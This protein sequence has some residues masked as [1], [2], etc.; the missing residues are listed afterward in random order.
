M[1]LRELKE[2][3][4]IAAEEARGLLTER[5]RLLDSADTIATF[6][7]EMSES[8]KTSELTEDQGLRP[9]LCQGGTGQARQGRH[10]LLHTHAG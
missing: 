1:E 3:L 2:T 10:P 9:L 8:L 7:E 4:E 5:R 6:A